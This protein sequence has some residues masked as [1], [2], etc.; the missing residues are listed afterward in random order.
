MSEATLTEA[1]K[2]ARTDCSASMTRKLLQGRSQTLVAALELAATIKDLLDAPATAH[3][4]MTPDER[5][6]AFKFRAGAGEALA[7]FDESKSVLAYLEKHHP[8][9]FAP[10][11]P[12]FE[13]AVV[14]KDGGPD[15]DFRYTTLPRLKDRLMPVFASD[16]DLAAFIAAQS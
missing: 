1:E 9:K 4:G 2:V 7:Y 15:F 13:F 16:A 6:A 8:A 14:L 10:F 12:A 3:A 11:I 5:L